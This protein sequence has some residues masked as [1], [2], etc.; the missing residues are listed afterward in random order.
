[1]ASAALLVLAGIAWFPDATREPERQESSTAVSAQ[2]A[3]IDRVVRRTVRESQLGV[4]A[5]AAEAAP[6]E[7]SQAQSAPQAILPERGIDMD[8][9]PESYSRGTYHGPMQRAPRT[10]APEAESSRSPE[11]FD[12][13]SAH[14]AIIEQ[15]A[16]TGRAFTFAVLRVSPG[17]DVQALDRS[18]AA[19]GSR[20]EGSAGAYVRVRVPGERSRLESIAALPG[21]LGIGSV[22][23]RIKAGEA[24]VRTMLA[25][26]ANEPVPVYIT[27][28]S[29]D[30][31]G[32]WRQ[33][34]SGFG[35]VVGAYDGDVRSYTANLP[36]AALAPV[37][38]ADFVL[39]VE[40][41]PIVVANH[42]SAVPVM[43]VDGFRRYDPVAQRFSGLTGSGIAVGVLDTGL[44]TRHWDIAH[45]RESICGANFVAEE[46]WDLWLDDN[47]HGTHVFGTIAGA[48]R[49]DPLLA[50]MAPELSHLRFGKVL[51]AYGFGSGDDIRRGMDY[52][53]RPSSCRREGVSSDAVK[54]LIV[55][56]SL[57]AS[58]LTF[59]GRGVGERKLDAVVQTHSQLYVVAQA[60]SGQHGF[61]N[62]GT[63]KNSLAVGA[64]DDSGV[65]AG[66]SSHGPTA[67]GRLAP[68]VVGTGVSVTSA[69]GGG[70]L[71]SH[72]TWSGTSMA[73]PAVAGVAALLMQAR[74]EFQNRPALARA[75]LM[76][77]AIRPDAYLAGPAQ[78]PV[79][80][81]AGPGAFQNLYG[82]GL[83]S[84][85]TSLYSDDNDRGW[86]IGSAS[87]RPD[88]DS[89]EY[90]DIQIPEGA[91]RLD[92]VLTW[93]EQ[94]ADTFT[95]SVLNN[96]DLWVDRGADCD[97]HACGEHASRSPLDNVEW[98]LI[99]NPAPGAYRIKAVPVEV[100]GESSTAAVAWVIHRGSGPPR[101]ELTLEDSSADAESEYLTVDVT[102][103]SDRYVASGTTIHLNCRPRPLRQCVRRAVHVVV[104]RTRPT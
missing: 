56:M 37:L 82:L 102:I 4:E 10:G 62:F 22:P 90:I 46:N 93:D 50:G 77:S 14:D 51:S 16:R 95:R 53:A 64:V 28:M 98:L 6:V 76:A 61:S 48:G 9:L 63:A 2:Q 36:G 75:R 67:D 78:L 30:P 18:L 103:E 65:I 60:N 33:A 89:Y 96:L 29:S 74:A 44:N 83:V 66:F 85:R 91:G 24:F 59:S 39:A 69:R 79:D 68:S 23:P 42:D 26:R 47:G 101:L 84:A 34:L 19:L 94:P 25:R 104:A 87:A 92:V 13:A 40:P 52:L 88:G 35:A 5:P 97:A 45:G 81:T 80:N 11:W 58:R 55:N 49:A 72:N 71:S 43:G 8:R 70:S 31:A 15:T 41:V 73:S 32:E 99:E 86:L 12:A 3:V 17:T 54:P 38:A 7:V 27:L 100:Y 57:A 20:I 1:M 21:V